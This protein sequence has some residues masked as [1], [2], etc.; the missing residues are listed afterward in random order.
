MVDTLLPFL[1]RCPVGFPLT[2]P[3][4]FFHA[5]AAFIQQLGENGTSSL[6]RNSKLELVNGA[7]DENDHTRKTDYLARKTISVISAGA[8][9][10]IGG[11]QKPVP[12]EQ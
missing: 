10:L 3:F 11:P 12:L 7:H 1:F 2:G 5:A 9:S 4:F 6:V 8:P